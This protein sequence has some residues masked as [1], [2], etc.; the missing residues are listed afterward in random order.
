MKVA[1]IQI[2][3]S[4][5][6]K[7]NLQKIDDFIMKCKN[8]HP[9]L[10]VVFLPEVFY[11]M[12]NG[13][14]KTTYL[15]EDQNEHYE[16]IKNI[17]IKHNVYLLGGSAATQVGEKT[18]NRAYH[19]SPVGKD[20]GHYDKQHLFALSLKGEDKKNLDESQIYSA[21]SKSFLLELNEFKFGISICFDLR[22]PEFYREYFKQGANVL[23]IGSAFTAATGKAHWETL[24]TARAIENQS[25]VIAANQWGK[26]NENMTSFGHSMIVDPWG[27][28]LANAGEGE[29][30]IV[31]KLNLKRIEDVR[32]RMNVFPT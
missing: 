22:F 16:N 32:R 13:V 27:E 18:F 23:S 24:V 14:E 9:D 26:H 31:A 29:C 17:A 4:G 7:K 1:I 6:Y 12:G 2:C 10:E 19:F 28:V 3:S 5:D 20:L 8:E 11:S 15:V 25:Y 21:G 30:F